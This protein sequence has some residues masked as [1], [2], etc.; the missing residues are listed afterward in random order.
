MESQP[1]RGAGPELANESDADLLVYMAMADDD[2]AC[3]RAAWEVFYRRHAEYLY[4]VCLRAYG[5]ILGG[6][7]GVA[8][9][10]AEAF[11]AAYENA[12]MFE[13]AGIADA[14]RLRLRARAW[15]GWIARRIVQDILRGR[16]RLP[17]RE[18]EPD[19]WQQVP[20]IE[21]AGGGP[22]AKEGLVRQAVESLSEREQLVIRTTFQWYRPEKQHQRLPND[23]AA[24]LAET[25]GTTPEN[26]RQIR[27]RAMK[28]ITDFI[29]A[30]TAEAEMKEKSNG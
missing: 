23:I 2:P 10:V 7:A 6:E 4:R 1:A 28:K 5:G 9:V 13:P 16:G 30:R 8:D 21:R 19:R 26:L 25:L 18:L 29:Q 11:R 24:D 12:H 22:S 27:S 3:A 15:L 17:T 14:D 20:A